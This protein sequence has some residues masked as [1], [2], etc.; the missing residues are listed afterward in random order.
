[1]IHAV[2]QRHGETLVQWKYWYNGYISSIREN[3]NI[4]DSKSQLYVGLMISLFIKIVYIFQHLY[5]QRWFTSS[6]QYNCAINFWPVKIPNSHVTKRKC[7][8]LL[9]NLWNQFDFDSIHDQKTLSDL[10]IYWRKSSYH[11]HTV[12]QS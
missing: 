11:F 3:T 1:M 8:K 4:I 6:C 10:R 7:S 9:V 2:L 12:T 5:W